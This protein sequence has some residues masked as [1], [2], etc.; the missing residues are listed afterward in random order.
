MNPKKPGVPQLVANPR[1]NHSRRDVLRGVMQGSAIAFALPWLESITGRT[2]I[3]RA[4]MGPSGFPLR[5]GLFFWGNGNNPSRWTPIGEGFGDEWALSEQLAPLAARKSKI[6]VVSGMSVK[7]PNREPHLSGSCGLLSGTVWADGTYGGP[8]IDQI[9]AEQ[10]GGETLFRSLQ[11]TATQSDGESFSGPNLR[12]P[13]EQS[14]FALYQRLFGPTFITPGS[15]GL[16][17]PK[18]GLRRSVLDVVHGELTT[19]KGR[20]SAL[21]RVRLEQHEDG[22]R[23]LE[24]RLSRLIEDPPSYA[25]CVDPG[26]PETDYPDIAGRPQIGAR[27]RAMADLLAMAFACDQTR[28]FGHYLTRPVGDVL[29]PGATKGHHSLTHDEGGDQPECNAITTACIGHFAELLDALDA[30]PEGDGTLLDHCAI[31]CTSD[32]SF[33]QTH[34]L[35]EMPLVVAGGADG[36]LHTDVHL[37]AVGKENASKLMLT[38]LRTLGVPALRFGEDDAETTASYTPI[39]A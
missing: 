33:G 6:A 26:S 10:I 27:N 32:V 14:P 19:L 5:F 16:V 39:E 24:T 23:D 22:V 29:F 34:S 13:A 35:D 31:L 4:A 9:L 11:T 8:T 15:G 2:P 3:A 21:D 18:L 25:A 7:L 20:V 17:D 38:L 37:R 30:I 12:N 28:I 36:A 1:A